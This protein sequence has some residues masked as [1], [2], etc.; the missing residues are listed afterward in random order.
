MKGM[1]RIASL[2]LASAV[3]LVSCEKKEGDVDMNEKL[4]VTSDRNVIQSDG[5]D[6][7]VLTAVIGGKD[8]TS[9]TVFYLK[10][11]MSQISGNVFKAESAGEYEIIAMYGTF[12]TEEPI[13]VT[14]IDME[15]P[16]V[17][18]DAEPGNTSFVHRAF[19]NQFTGTACG[20]CP[21]MVRALRAA[22]E[23]EETKEK[24]VLAAIH[25]FAAGDPAY[26]T[27]CPKAAGYPYLQI[28]M[29]TSFS[30]DQDPY[31][32]SGLLKRIVEERTSSPAKVGISSNPVLKDDVLAV[33]VEVKA[34]Y[35]GEYNLGV[36]FMQDNVYGQQTDKLGIVAGDNSFNYHHNC[37]RVCDSRYL[38]SYVGYPLGNIKAGETASRTFVFTID[39]TAWKLKNMDDIH[40]AAF[41]TSTTADGKYYEVVNAVDCPY[42][43][44]VPY[45]YSK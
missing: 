7:A 38:N 19:L 41:V 6:G 8:V 5:T 20:Y 13:V 42:D 31:A 43:E 39:R 17:A 18:E 37:V 12:Y 40:F 25:S 27:A 2:L 30:Y 3:M 22:F 24:T 14:A 11:D 10:K 16:S 36:W 23:D 33:T 35:D 1:I 28:D 9:E 26:I 21:G 44:P 15:I 29:A 45:E 4:F 34:A 32:E